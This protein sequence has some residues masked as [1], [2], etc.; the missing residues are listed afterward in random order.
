MLMV[1]AVRLPQMKLHA[2]LDPER[3]PQH[4]GVDDDLVHTLARLKGLDAARLTMRRF[5]RELAGLGGFLGR[6]GDGEPGWRTLWAG[7][8][9][10]SLIHQGRTLADQ[11]P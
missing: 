6:K 5:V 1:V 2:R 9:K 11:S 8:N 10:L 3:S 4:C 7:W